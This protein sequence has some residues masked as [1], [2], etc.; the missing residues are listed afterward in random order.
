VVAEEYVPS[1]HSDFATIINKIKETNPNVIYANL[2]G[3]SAVAFYKAFK[4]Y[5]LDAE[6]M[7]IASFCSDENTFNALG[8]ET[9][10]GHYIS[11]NYVNT[12]ESAENTEFI[13]NYKALYGDDTEVT[14][15]AEAAY[16]SVYL[17]AYALEAI[18]DGEYTAE[19]I[20]AS[21]SG[22][23]IDAPGGAVKVDGDNFHLYLKACIAKV[24]DDGLLDVVYESDE[25][26]KPAP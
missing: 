2:N 12:I 5:G 11:I 9:S 4:D 6:T 20:R 3:D 10:A 17:L 26:I 25:L 24:G 1:G 14:S 19:N 16:K 22:V 8:A 18:G 13:A 15:V 23:E 7:P 21:L